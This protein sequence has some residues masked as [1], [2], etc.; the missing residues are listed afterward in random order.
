MDI[1]ISLCAGSD[2]GIHGFDTLRLVHWDPNCTEVLEGPPKVG[3]IDCDNLTPTPF[4]KWMKNTDD[5]NTKNNTKN[6]QN[7]QETET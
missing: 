2:K 4:K 7:H 6:K 1:N 5:Q 3:A